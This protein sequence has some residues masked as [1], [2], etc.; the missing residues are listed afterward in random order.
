MM[1]SFLYRPIMYTVIERIRRSMETPD[2]SELGGERL[3]EPHAG[4][5]HIFKSEL[6]GEWYL[7]LLA[8][9]GEPI[10]AS[11]G[12]KNLDDVRMLH[13]KYFPLFTLSDEFGE[14]L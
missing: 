1:A 9:N 8:G 10:M 6:N 4:K 13:D 14:P 7:R 3:S 5:A 11:E 2:F 12:H